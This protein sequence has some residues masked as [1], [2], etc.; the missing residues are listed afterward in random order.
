MYHK[1]KEGKKYLIAEMENE[2]LVNTIKVIANN[3]KD[4]CSLV[5]SGVGA[6]SL[7]KSQMVTTGVKK[8]IDKVDDRAV[9]ARLESTIQHIG[10]YIMEAVIR[11]LDVSKYI[12]EALGRSAKI[13]PVYNINLL[14]I[15]QDLIG[16]SDSYDEYEPGD[17][18]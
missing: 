11:G 4:L 17:F 16:S 7:S 8:I 5:D 10:P 14:K 12:Q 1:D 9:T 13:N 2:H 18:A 6:L 3:I 15:P